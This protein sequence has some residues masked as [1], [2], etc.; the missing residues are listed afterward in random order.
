MKTLLTTFLLTLAVCT[1]WTNN[2][3]SRQNFID[4]Y[5]P[6]AV[7]DMMVSGIPASIKLA[8]AVIESGW[9]K[10]RTAAEG[11]NFFC[12]KCHTGWSGDTIMQKDDEQKES[13]FRRYSNYED[14][15]KDHTKFLTTRPN[16]RA[17]FGYAK[18]D[19]VSWAKGLKAANY[20]TRSDYDE[21]LI[22]VITDYGLYLYDYARPARVEMAPASVQRNT[23][24]GFYA[25][26][27][28]RNAS[29]KYPSDKPAVQSVQSPEILEAPIYS[30]GTNS[31]FNKS[32]ELPTPPP[33]RRED[34]PVFIGGTP[35][36]R[37]IQP[38]PDS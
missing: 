19:Y 31:T 21:V 2:S 12:I 32:N 35:K 8:Q 13:C 4:T 38:L 29:N 37:V 26:G 22:R 15:F 30:I 14:S 34:M 18:T 7:N 11:N 1:A 23:D 20:A 24:D 3:F 28:G 5:A 6:L 33:D 36:I 9:G 16:Y 25:K 17:L 27:V 10:S